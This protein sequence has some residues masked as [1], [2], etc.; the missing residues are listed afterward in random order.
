MADLNLD[1]AKTALLSLHFH[2]ALVTN[3][4]M[5]KK[6]NLAQR[7]KAAQDAARKAGI[8][9]IHVGIPYRP[10][11]FVTP[12]NK[13]LTTVR[14]RIPYPPGEGTPQHL[15]AFIDG[16]GPAEGE[17]TISSAGISAFFGSPLGH[18]LSAKDVNTVVMMGAVTEFVIESTARY[19]VDANYRVVILE[20][21]CI[22]FTEEAHK[23][24]IAVLDWMADISDSASFV[25]SVQSKQKAR[26]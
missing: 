19:A 12:R 3:N 11:A 20:D 14:G 25:E 10:P 15:N 21:C 2:N 7:V 5:A 6:G 8:T 16:V 13:F 17:L 26:A 22:G 9:V 24:S 23:C 1:S 18:L 4:P